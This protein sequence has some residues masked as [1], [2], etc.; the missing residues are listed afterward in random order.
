[1]FPWC[2]GAVSGSDRFGQPEDLSE[3]SG[4]YEGTLPQR[5]TEYHIS[6]DGLWGEK[7]RWRGPKWLTRSTFLVPGTAAGVDVGA[8][9]AVVV[10]AMGAAEVIDALAGETFGR[11]ACICNNPLAVG[12]G[13]TGVCGLVAGHV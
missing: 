13:K 10:P 1:L 11:K 6:L 3:R 7:I 5:N 2:Q 12:V 4:Q 9:G 8:V